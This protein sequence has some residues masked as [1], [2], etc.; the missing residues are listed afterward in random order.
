[1]LV[2]ATKDNQ[3][4]SRVFRSQNPDEIVDYV[5]KALAPH[6]MDT[7][8]PDAMRAKL[9]T[10]D[11]AQVQIVDIEYGTDVW[12]D[13]GELESG[14]LVHAAM[15]GVGQMRSGRDETAVSPENLYV[16]SPG[17]PFNC[18]MTP[19]CRHLTVKISNAAFED[20]LT[21][22]L[23]IATTRPLVFY[24]G[25]EGSR[26]LPA[27]WRNMLN[28]IMNQ[29]EL[30]PALMTNVHTQKQYS[31]VLIDM[32]LTNY[33]NSYSDQIALYGN[34]ISPW[35]VR[36]ARDAIHASLEDMI[37][38]SDLA[39]QVGVSVRSLQN[40]FRQFIGLTPVEYVRRHRLE[41]LHYA[42][43]HDGNNRSVT[44]LMLESGIVNFGRYAQYYRQQYGC[45]PSDT[46]R[47]RRIT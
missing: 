28:H 13:P 38:I 14:Y 45:R 19:E 9:T 10:F 33:C 16:T 40:G 5:G 2:Q 21:R 4:P 12:I 15:S 29:I 41:K 24:P 30:A 43:M 39:Q 8:N 35:Y 42:L 17:K 32:L 44:E 34:D 47:S 23:N 6:R 37:S 20:Y 3:S 26:E 22:V 1:M 25:H 11:I 36:R 27:V 46:L 31:M 7:R 18:R